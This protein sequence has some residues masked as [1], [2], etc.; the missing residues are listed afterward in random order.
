MPSGL[1]HQWCLFGS[2]FWLALPSEC[3]CNA[4]ALRPLCQRLLEDVD[5][6]KGLALYL[7]VSS[8]HRL[9]LKSL[10]S[11][12]TKISSNTFCTAARSAG[13]LARTSSHNLSTGCQ[14]DRSVV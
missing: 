1:F 6:L 12:N 8:S 14:R 4:F 11:P 13:V 7:A 3:V 9:C 10:P 2:W 5:A